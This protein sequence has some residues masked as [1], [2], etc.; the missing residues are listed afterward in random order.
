M[1]PG[2]KTISEKKL[3]G[4]RITMSLFVERILLI[5][6]TNLLKIERK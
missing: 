4:K 6:F 3:T 2:I 5:S 1:H